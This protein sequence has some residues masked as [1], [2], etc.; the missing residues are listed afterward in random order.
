MMWRSFLHFAF[1]VNTFASIIKNDADKWSLSL[2]GEC[3]DSEPLESGMLV[4]ADGPFAHSLLNSWVSG[5]LSVLNHC[6]MCRCNCCFRQL[7]ILRSDW[8]QRIVC[9][10][11]T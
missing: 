4:M 3:N 8:R 6:V 7:F 10:L 9:V 2:P 11:E 1:F 5:I